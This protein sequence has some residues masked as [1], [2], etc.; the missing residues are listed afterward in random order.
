[1][2]FSELDAFLYFYGQD[3]LDEIMPLLCRPTLHFH[4]LQTCGLIIMLYTPFPTVCS[5]KDAVYHVARNIENYYIPTDLMG[6]VSCFHDNNCYQKQPC[7]RVGDSSIVPTIDSSDN[8]DRPLSI[9]SIVSIP[10]GEKL[11]NKTK[12]SLN[13]LF[14]LWL[15]E[16]I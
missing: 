11:L 15:N 10:P 9:L 4:R 7:G 12:S 3:S 14:L 2:T 6:R 1:M 5:F 13:G 16:Q 8:I